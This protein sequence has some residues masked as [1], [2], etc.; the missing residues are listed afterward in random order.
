MYIIYL[1]YNI[2]NMYMIKH[3]IYLNVYIFIYHNII[4]I[5]CI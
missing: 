5:I 3:N 4:Y 1:L 2:Y